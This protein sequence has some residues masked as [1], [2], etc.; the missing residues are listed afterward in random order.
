MTTTPP[1]GPPVPVRVVLPDG[2][3]LTARLWSRRETPRGW[4]YEVG[5]PAYR[6]TENRMNATGC[7]ISYAAATLDTAGRSR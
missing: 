1:D 2:Q 3:E 6:N 4:L 7:N 5:L